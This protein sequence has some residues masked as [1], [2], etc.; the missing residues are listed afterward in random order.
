MPRQPRLKRLTSSLD[1]MAS[2]ATTP[3]AQFVNRRVRAYPAATLQAFRQLTRDLLAG[4]LRVTA[5][6]RALLARYSLNLR[7][8][9]SASTAANIRVHLCRLPATVVR[10]L[11]DISLRFCQY[12]NNQTMVLV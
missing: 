7:K 9:A 11:A 1:V 8:L 10:T 12:G 4:R 2:L 3:S 6:E 5:S